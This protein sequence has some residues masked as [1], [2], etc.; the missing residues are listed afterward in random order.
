MH[1]Y[2]EYGVSNTAMEDVA[3]QA[4][5]GRAT[6]YRHFSN[7]EALITEVMTANLVQAQ[8]RLKEQLID[9]KTAE[10]FF[11]E[12]AIIII[13]ESH[14]RALTSLLF[15][16]GSSASLINRIS[17]SDPNIVAMGNE[18]IAPFYE[19]AKALIEKG[20]RVQD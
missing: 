15:D 12:S 7:Q 16:E 9:C 2:R 20:T 14:K 4:G 6:L 3:Q 19:R 1:C 18:L 8:A 10:E 5:V 17:F 11:V 13:Q